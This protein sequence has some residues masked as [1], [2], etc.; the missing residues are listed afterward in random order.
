M[1]NGDNLGI[2]SALTMAAEDQMDTNV[3]DG[4]S[5]D[6]GNRLKVLR[7]ERG[8][9]MRSLARSSSLSA[10]A[11]SMIER[12]LTSPSVSTL[13]K[14]AAALEVPITAFFRVIPE[15]K[16]IVHS[17]KELHNLIPFEGVMF[18]DQGG[19]AFSGRMES[20]KIT[21]SPNGGSGTH[22][23]MHTGSEFVY[24]LN[25]QVE[26][27]IEGKFYLLEAGDSLFLAPKLVHRWKN[28][29]DRTTEMIIVVSSFEEGESP[30]EF[31]LAPFNSAAAGC[32]ED[33][34]EFEE[35]EA[36]EA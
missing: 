13:T 24:C 6:V 32:N 11:L 1:F 35:D 17:T 21:V 23:M 31:H 29:T 8:I 2:M 15:R 12:G 27:E 16:R 34:E 14:I 22:R 18:E 28:P 4:G 26:F 7:E 3:K 5:I 33:D 30:L 25:G 19:E 10:N 36:A 9:S 20:F